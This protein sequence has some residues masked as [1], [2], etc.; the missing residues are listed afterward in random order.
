MGHSEGEFEVHRQPSSFDHDEES[1]TPPATENSP[2]GNASP[3]HGST[4]PTG[5]AG[6]ILRWSPRIF[7]VAYFIFSVSVYTMLPTEGTKVFW[8]LYLTIGTL[9]ASITVLEAFDGLSLLKLGRKT[10]AKTAKSGLLDD[11]KLPFVEL[12]IEESSRGSFDDEILLRAKTVYPTEK[13]RI[14]VL[15][16]EHD[17]TALFHHLCY[18]QDRQQ[19]PLPE[20]TAILTGNQ[21]PHPHAIRHAVDRLAAN[22]NIDL[23]QSRTVLTRR[24][25]AGFFRAAWSSLASLQHDA[26]HCLVLPGRTVTWETPISSGV[27]VYGRTLALQNAMRAAASASPRQ[28]SVALAFSALAQNSKSVYDM[29]VITY[30]ECARSLI[31]SMRVQLREAVQW[32]ASMRYLSLVF[33][34]AKSSATTS[35]K[36]TSPATTPKRTFKQRVCIFYTL[37]LQRLGSHAILQ[38][39]S[40]ALAMLIINP[41]NSAAEF[42]SQ[43]FFPYHISIWL[44]ASGL[45]CL[46]GTIAMVH[47]A[48]S[49]FA[50]KGWTFP[51]VVLIWPLMLLLGAG[52]DVYA[53]VG[54][55]LGSF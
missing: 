18:T 28:N 7:M 54:V 49:E 38:Y 10:I 24:K 44:I 30:T 15:P 23:I 5:I 34:K 4:R 55:M 52:V 27:P 36:S 14:T 41:P 48:A 21:R 25:G 37:L 9:L 46:F 29:S 45:L 12:I 6:V 32:T 13:L 19:G 50:P 20:I 2:Y 33:T 43:I 16:R 40:L 22:K 11:P 17:N 42:S 31:G 8:F 51:G 35:E 39:F 47:H 26:T 53:Q 3:Q 1:A